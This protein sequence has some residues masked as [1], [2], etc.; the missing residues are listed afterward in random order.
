IEALEVKL[1]REK[2]VPEG[3][4]NYLSLMTEFTWML[5]RSAPFFQQERDESIIALQERLRKFGERKRSTMEELLRVLVELQAKLEVANIPSALI[6]G[7]AVGAWGNPRLTSDIDIKV[8]LR[9]AERKRLLA[10]LGKDYR[11][12]H[13]DPDNALS[14]NGI[15]FVLSPDGKRIDIALA[16]TSFDEELIAR[17][18]LVEV[19]P[20]L[21]A[22]VCSAED[23]IVLKI[24]AIRPQDQQDVATIIQRQG[25]NLDDAYILKW[26]KEFEQAIDDST[27]V[28]TYQRLKKRYHRD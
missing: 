16:D 19:L 13:A 7:L 2:T 9:R 23:L 8:L 20:N 1:L 21:K 27:L 10:L 17:A 25:N 6:G 11:S 4:R 3:I 26:L 12:L 15:V 28:S 18:Q 5:E 22:R 14:Q 24:I